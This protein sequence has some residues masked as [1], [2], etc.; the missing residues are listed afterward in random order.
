MRR[1]NYIWVR[2][3][4]NHVTGVVQP[5]Q[6]QY[7]LLASYRT[8]SGVTLNIPEF[9]IWRIHIR[10]SIQFG[11]SPATAVANSACLLT[12][13]VDTA[14]FSGLPLTLSEPYSEQY[15]MYD[16][17]YV[18]ELIMNGFNVPAATPT[19]DVLAA[20]RNYDIK[21]HRRLG[22]LN[23]TLWLTLTPQG[24]MEQL[25]SSITYSILLRQR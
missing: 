16:N 25:T 4:E 3:A 15:L 21:S 7:D 18:S 6:D 11:L 14:D 12:L 5:N 2:G 19:I 23:E 1:H 13:F 24:N 10:I 8:R 20:V 22:N 17:L 9:T